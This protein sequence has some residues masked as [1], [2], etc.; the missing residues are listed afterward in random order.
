MFPVGT[1]PC[2]RLPTSETHCQLVAGT[3]RAFEA[4]REGRSRRDSNAEAQKEG[5][6]GL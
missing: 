1:E 6:F 2:S 5:F 3:V 4:L